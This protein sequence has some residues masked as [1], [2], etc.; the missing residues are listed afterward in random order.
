MSSYASR[1]RF[2]PKLHKGA[3]RYYY[4][5]DEAVEL[6]GMLPSIGA[7]VCSRSHWSFF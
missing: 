7:V 6:I 4:V 3:P 1:V 5:V 2:V